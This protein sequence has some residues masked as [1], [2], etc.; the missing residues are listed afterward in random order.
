MGPP[1]AGSIAAHG[2]RGTEQTD[3]G[4]EGHRA[5][6]RGT[7]PYGGAQSRTEG[8][9]TARRGTEPYGGHR[10]VRRGVRNLEGT[11][12][13]SVGYG[14]HRAVYG[15]RYGGNTDVWRGV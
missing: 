2:D 7:E 8:H 9:G 11:E 15:V 14:E 12:P 6:R 10:A 4:T 5:V 13:Y 3:A 1:S